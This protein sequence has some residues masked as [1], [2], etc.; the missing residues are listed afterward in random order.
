[1]K[2]QQKDNYSYCS[3]AGQTDVGR[4]RK[5]NEDS[6]A[7]FTT[8]N[9]LVAVVCDGMGGHVG[10]A[11]ASSVAIDAIHKFLD[12]QYF[13]DPREAIGY[14]INAANAAILSRAAM[15]PELAG[16]GS[17]CVLLIVRDG[18]VFL[19]HVGDS[20]I[21]LVRE[22]SIMQLTKDQ[23]FVQTLVDLGQ[24]TKEEAEHHP[25]KNEITNALG[26]P[27]MTP[28][29]V[30]A[31][32]IDPQVG[33]CFVLCSDGLSGMVDDNHIEKTVS[34]QRE[35]ST[36]QRADI[37][38]QM[39]NANGGLDNITVELVEFPISPAAVVNSVSFFRKNIKWLSV[40]VA[41]V[42]VVVASVLCL[43]Y[44]SDEMNVVRKIT[45]DTQFKK[46]GKVFVLKTADENTV[47]VLDTLGNELLKCENVRNPLEKV[48]TNLN[49]QKTPDGIIKLLFEDTFV[50]GEYND[51]AY[52]KVIGENQ[53][54]LVISHVAIPSIQAE[55]QADS[56]PVNT[57]MKDDNGTVDNGSSEESNKKEDP[58]T[59]G[60]GIVDA[61]INLKGGGEQENIAGDTS[62]KIIDLLPIVVET[63]WSE[64]IDSIVVFTIVKDDSF[65]KYLLQKDGKP[66]MFFD[67]Y[68]VEN[69]NIKE[70]DFPKEIVKL[71]NIRNTNNYEVVLV[72]KNA[73][74]KNFEIKIRNA[75]GYTG[76]GNNRVS[77]KINI[78]FNVSVNKK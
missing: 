26:L 66:L 33:D 14:A 30:R 38:V 40:I 58:T 9:G 11:V 39:A 27:N 1:M 16:M 34:K 54:Y 50:D 6:G 4:K 23:S 49:L 44:R 12:E 63:N 13:E 24:I 35:Y 31:D 22:K 53:C 36:Q 42:V 61:F 32:A 10:G 25:R 59:D 60:K 48:I 3:I 2:E 70:I 71:I 5:A 17:T 75:D 74:R 65:Y 76:S 7:H 43:V 47:V 72:N 21:Y 62:V 20:R 28:A 19:G 64:E 67:G 73:N 56:D 57:T 51:S 37:L 46:N 78:V 41:C 15:Q 45:P 68:Y 69:I 18:K 52:V 29:I 77:C 8:I 55:E